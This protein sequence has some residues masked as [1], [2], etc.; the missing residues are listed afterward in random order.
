[1]NCLSS[2]N[3]TVF[4]VC[5]YSLFMPLGTHFLDSLSI[6]WVEY[7][8][9]IYCKVN[10]GSKV[11]NSSL[12]LHW[13]FNW[14]FYYSILLKFLLILLF[15]EDSKFK[16]V[17]L[18]FDWFYSF[19]WNLLI[20]IWFF[21]LIM[22]YNTSYFYIIFCNCYESTGFTWRSLKDTYDTYFFDF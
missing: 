4:L 15:V 1:M 14:L 2:L 22:S 16:L 9:V 10:L 5:A 21:F 19:P 3:G 20:A 17:S 18:Y 8:V 11:R 13:F 12:T 6:L 7:E